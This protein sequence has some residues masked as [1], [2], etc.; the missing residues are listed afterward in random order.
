MKQRYYVE[1]SNWIYLR[2]E[3]NKR[4]CVIDLIENEVTSK[5]SD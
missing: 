4:L 3:V 5:L 1:T 2:F